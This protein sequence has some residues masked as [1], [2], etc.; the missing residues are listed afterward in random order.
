MKFT[1]TPN[2]QNFRN[3][4]CTE[5]SGCRW[6]ATATWNCDWEVAYKVCYGSKADALG[7]E[8]QVRFATHNRPPSDHRQAII[9][10][11]R[12]HHLRKEIVLKQSRKIIMYW[13]ENIK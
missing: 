7:T 13:C 2:R 5:C 6:S 10:A 1:H 8:A 3:S 12:R 9:V 11:M 4:S